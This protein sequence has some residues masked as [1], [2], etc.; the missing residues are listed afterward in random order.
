[1]VG[2]QV[3]AADETVAEEEG[4]HVVAEDPL[5]LAFVH[6]DQV[7][8]AEEAAKE[9]AVPDEV[10]ERAEEHGR[11]RVA[12]ELGLCRDDDLRAAVVQLDARD[13][14]VADERVDVRASLARAAAEAAVL[15]DSRLRQRSAA[16]DR[17]ERE[18]AM[19]LRGGRRRRVEIRARDHAL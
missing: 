3:G 8:E 13:E 16:L 15:R 9:G 7:V 4:Q 10:V 17:A 2:L 5:R 1:A 6:L 14:A 18:A 19:E 11:A 12:V